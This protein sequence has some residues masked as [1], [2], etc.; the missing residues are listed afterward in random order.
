LQ[1]LLLLGV[2]V[3][4]FPATFLRG[5]RTVP[6]AL[7]YEQAP[8]EHYRPADLDPVKNRNTSEYLS[9]F[10]KLHAAEHMAHENSEWPLWNPLELTGVPLLANYQSAVFFPLRFPHWFIDQFLADTIFLLLR[11]WLCGFTAYLCARGFGLWV[12]PARF[13]SLAWMMSGICINWFYWP[14]PDVIGLVPLVLLGAEYL[15]MKQYRRGFA[16]LTVGGILILLAGHPETAFLGCLGIGGY[17]VLR[18]AMQRPSGRHLRRCLALG[19]AAWFIALLVSAPEILPFIEYVSNSSTS[20]TSFEHTFSKYSGLPIQTLVCLLVPRF[21]GISADGNFWLDEADNS[22]TTAY[23]YMGAVTWATLSLLFARGSYSSRMRAQIIGLTVP[24]AL[25]VFPALRSHPLE[26]LNQIP[27]WKYWYVTFT[28]FALPLLGALGI[29]HWIS[30]KRT[31][32]D[33]AVPIAVFLAPF[34]LVT[35]LFLFHRP[36]LAMKGLDQY[37]LRQIVYAA[38]FGGV[39]LVIAAGTCFRAPAR[40][41]AGLP[42]LVLAVDMVFAARDLLPTTPKQYVYPETQL[43]SELQALGHPTRISVLTSGIDSGLL[44]PYRIEQLHGYDP[45]YPRRII[46]YMGETY[47]EAWEQAERLCSLEY[48]LFPH[49]RDA[50]Y[51][52]PAKMEFVATADGIDIFRNPDALPRAFLVP[53]LETVPDSKTLF[54]RMHDETFDPAKMALT[55]AAIEPFASETGSGSPEVAHIERWTSTKAT[56][57]IDASVRSV[58]VLTDAFYPGWNAYV[59][60]VETQVF[61]VYHNFRGVIVEPG[62]S[63]VEFRFEPASL[64]IGLW[65]SSVSLLFM[66]L[67]AV[68]TLVRGRHHQSSAPGSR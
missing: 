50:E 51:G 20:V 42:A 32:R 5:E 12:G 43:T 4:L 67:W 33:I 46:E 3:C 31:P 18:L 27:I 10:A 13:F 6:G 60:G 26:A 7:L 1:A 21:F 19:A 61:P 54:Q 11:L 48:Y 52:P 57:Q 16:T 53:R 39:G 37:V 22:N 8:W 24:A 34:A 65:A 44:Q 41:V 63:R 40:M 38:G 55:E 14:L 64:S 2:L 29:Q 59:D 47:P 28:L 35:V 68:W 62:V 23:L 9:F 30:T 56:V 58:L 25:F 17:F 66:L 36:V 49:V 45:L 15:L